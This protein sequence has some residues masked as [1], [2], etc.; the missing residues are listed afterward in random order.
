M[1]DVKWIKI[2]TDIFNDEK[3]ILIEHMPEADSIIVI[4]F[5]LLCMAGKQNN[6]G[7]FMLNDKLAYTE[8]MLATIFR[9]P[10][11]I[12]RLALQAFEQFGMIEVVNNTITIPNWEKHQSLDKLAE[13]KEKNRLRVAAHR[14]RQKALASGNDY[15]NVTPITSNATEEEK[16]EDI[17]ID[18]EKEDKKKIDYQ[19]IADMYN[20]TCV[21]LPRITVLSEGRKKAIKAR[22]KKYS[23][24]QFELLFKKTE[25][26]EFLKGANDRNWTATFDWLMKDA[27]FAKVLDGNYDNKSV[28]NTTPRNG[29]SIVTING[30]E[31]EYRNG[32]YYIP[33]GNGIAV[34]PYAKT[35]DLF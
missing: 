3:I 35:T 4:W 5:K 26:S 21:S 16:E 27:N 10:I 15:G 6:G 24:E 23:I 28:T 29:S 11:N 2:C 13:A 20:K 7:V 14:E 1:A 9:K 31:F 17:E 34:D 8:E 33:N 25:E 22:L 30:K 18:I 32:Q 19:L 12:V